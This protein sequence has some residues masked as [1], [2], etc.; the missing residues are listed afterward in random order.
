MGA[1]AW[2]HF[3][4]VP[5]FP[6]PDDKVRAISEHECAG[7]NIATSLVALRRWGLKCR[8]SAML[9]F[10]SCSRRIIDD[11]DNEGVLT[12]ALIRREDAD[13]R[14]STII[15]D[16]R[17]GNRSVV[18]GPHKVPP[19]LPH[20]VNRSWFESARVLH[21]DSSMDEC[22]VE[23]AALAREMGLKVTIDCER[24]TP[25]VLEVMRAC[26]YIIA[27]MSFAGP[28]TQQEKISLA[29]YG[30]HLQTERAVI[31][32]DGA[33]GCEYCCGEVAFHQPAF[34]V[35]VV[36]CTGAG[37]VFHAAFIYG[38]L[39]AWDIKKTVRFASWSAAHACRELG[40]RKGIPTPEEIHEYL[41]KDSQA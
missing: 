16:H 19:I 40:G 13:G 3:L 8:V 41:R 23:A 35:P 17:N 28:F 26:D 29:A 39:A 5:R 2:D 37:D 21:L 12:D 10:D 38:L 6:E 15:V 22:G 7:G 14:R 32:T 4:V 9:G 33:R 31:V 27:P 24:S 30:L 25:R 18:S 11:L 36:D 1:V 34:N 20:H